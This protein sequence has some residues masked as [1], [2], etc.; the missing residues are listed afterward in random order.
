MGTSQ[1][2]AQR[3]EIHERIGRGGMGDVYLGRDTQ[4]GEMVAIKVLKPEIVEIDPG[5]VERFEREGEALRK[6]NHPNIVNILEMI[7]EDEQHYLVMEYVAGGSLADLLRE[8]PQLPISRVLEIALDLADA[9]TRA[10]RLNIIHRDIKPANVL[11]AEDGTPRLTDFGTARMGDRTRVTQDG[12]LIGTYIYLSPEACQGEEPDT[13]TDIW[14]FGVMLYEMLTGQCPFDADNPGAVINAILSKPITDPEVFRTDVPPTLVSLL[15]QMLEKDRNQRISS[16][17]LVGAEIEAIIRNLDTPIKAAA[18]D[19]LARLPTDPRDSMFSTPTPTDFATGAGPITPASRTTSTAAVTPPIAAR[20]PGRRT[21]WIAGGIAA[22]A[23]AIVVLAIVLI[24]GAVSQT[25]P[26]ATVE[27]VASD[28]IMVLVAQL[29][30]LG[31]EREVTRF[32]VDDLTQTLEVS[33]PFS[34]I[35]VREYPEIITSS[36]E[37]LAAA[38]A[39]QATVVVWGNTSADLIEL[40]VQIGVTDAFSL[41][42]IPRDTLDQSTNVRV[43]MTDARR[44]SVTPHV[45][46]IVIGLQNADGNLYE[47]LRSIATLDAIDVIPAEVVGSGVATHVYLYAQAYLDDSPDAID[48]IN[49]ALELDS[50]NPLLYIY[51]SGILLRQGSQDDARRDAQTAQRLGPEG[52]TS[53]LYILGNDALLSSDID[54]AISY[55][56][57]IISLRPDDWFPLSYRGAL[58]YLKGDYDHAKIDFDSA[59]A[60]EPNEN[61]PYVWA[62][63][64]ALHEGRVKNAMLLMNTILVEYPDLSLAKRIVEATFGDSVPHI[65]GP[66]LSGIGNL[67]IGQY[68]AVIQDAEATIAVNDQL[69]DPYFMQGFAYCNLGNYP[70]AEAAYTRALE[71]EPGFMLVYLLRAEVRQAQGD[72]AGALADVELVRNS[73][74]AEPLAMLL[75]QAPEAGVSCRTFLNLDTDSD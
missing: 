60:L 41:I 40:N 5:I 71:L 42:Q 26:I 36:E 11:L 37:A 8:T 33:V 50:A 39:N 38:E 24:T 20:P 6:L 27:P 2:I 35:R 69:P 25:P 30:P 44:E 49:A 29:E 53:P 43:H 57:E 67:M 31:E 74:Q 61:F 52:W 7:E 63:M 3:Y 48:E 46:G 47:L 56:S 75:E 68:Y 32:I 64:L 73:D 22:A 72:L 19:L 65:F 15:F 62:V 66:L 45:I 54:R 10:H 51:R 34:K 70:D 14:S 9:L 13:R 12:A 1:T 16:V 58:Y 23:V 28:E 17:R 55:Y 4:T 18:P 59:I 21:I